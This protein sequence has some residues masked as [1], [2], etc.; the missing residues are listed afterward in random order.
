MMQGLEGMW[1]T[2][3]QKADNTSSP[4]I[5]G[6]S[7]SQD[8]PQRNPSS[9]PVCVH[10]HLLLLPSLHPRSRP[11]PPLN[12]I[13]TY[14]GP[15]TLTLS[16]SAPG[17]TPSLPSFCQYTTSSSRHLQA[18]KTH[19]ALSDFQVFLYYLSTCRQPHQLRLQLGHTLFVLAPLHS[20]F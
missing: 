1:Y 17:S 6:P 20:I 18:H 7:L 3:F 19:K 16:Q 2:I 14:P 4:C 11:Q 8:S 10:P 13:S 12:S 5:Q 15:T 9:P